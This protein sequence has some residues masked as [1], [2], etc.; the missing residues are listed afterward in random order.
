MEKTDMVHNCGWFGMNLYLAKTIPLSIAFSKS[1]AGPKASEKAT[2]PA[3][4][5]DR[6]G[7]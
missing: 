3:G 1:S 6:R 7:C 5:I 4:Y 2:T